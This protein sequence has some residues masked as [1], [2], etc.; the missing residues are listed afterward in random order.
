MVTPVKYLCTRLPQNPV[1]G[2]TIIPMAVQQVNLTN[3]TAMGVEA[4]DLCSAMRTKFIRS[5][6]GFT[7]LTTESGFRLIIR[8]FAFGITPR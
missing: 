6:I 7:T 5:F 2:L 8:L 1:Y 4:S 3:S